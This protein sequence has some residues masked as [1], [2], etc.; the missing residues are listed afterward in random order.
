[1]SLLALAGGLATAGVSAASGLFGARRAAKQTN[2]N[3]ERT[4]Q[5]QREAQD[6]EY[7]RNLEQWERE[8]AYNTPAMQMQRLTE[9]G[10]NPNLVYGNG[11]AATTAAKSPQYEAARPDYSGQ[12]S[13]SAAA[14]Q[15]IM[16]TQ[17]IQQAH[18]QINNIKAQNKLIRAQAA[19][20]ESERLAI[21]FDYGFKLEHRNQSSI[22]RH[23]DALQAINRT[24]LQESQRNI[25]DKQEWILEQT[26]HDIVRRVRQDLEN[27]SRQGLKLDSD[28]KRQLAE[29]VRVEL[30]NKY[31]ELGISPSDNAILRIVSRILRSIF[32]D[33]KF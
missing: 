12:R 8:N 29:T 24:G 28:Y 25:S 33:F 11:S 2:R 4:I 26:R 3:I 21:D 14:L 7:Q 19:K 23:H 15:S 18:A 16:T 5:A 13:P 1:M 32:P 30:D 27:A 6:L 22:I 20:V 10:L 17:G 31:R 9:A